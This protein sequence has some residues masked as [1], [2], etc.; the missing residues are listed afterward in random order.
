MTLPPDIPAAR[1]WSLTALRQPDALDAAD[2]AALPAGGEPVLPDTGGDRRTTTARRPSR[3]V[4]SDPADSP[5]G[6]WIQTDPRQ[7]L[8][9]DPAPLQPARSRSSTSPGAR[10]RSSRELSNRPHAVRDH[11][12]ERKEATHGSTANDTPVL[13]LLE[14]MTAASLAASS[15]DERTLMLVRIAALVA[16]DAPPVSY[17]MN[18]E[19]TAEV[20]ID[21]ERV[22][23]VLA[24]I[25][26]I[27]GTARVAA[28]TSNIVGALAL[29]IEVAELESQGDAIRRA[30]AMRREMTWARRFRL[31][32][33]LLES[34]WV[35]P[36]LG[37]V[38]G[39]VLGIVVSLADEHLGAPS[40]WQYSPSTASA[41]LTAIVGATAAL[42][43]FVV[44]VT[45]LV[46]QMAT[47]TFSARDPAPLVPRPPAEGDARG[48]RWHPHVLVLGAP[49][50]R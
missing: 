44:T 41:V 16:V 39:R 21:A 27:V 19:A 40:L 14:D 30:S 17:V 22:R 24:A 7:G 29:A 32:E 15:L 10:A 5:E 9:P 36:V 11:T 31:R 4:R 25:A 1:F 48:A 38:L 46:V 3:S 49:A 23:G 2:A 20:G 8:V 18:L 12:S 26:P 33:S 50:D 37:A 47:G 13:D 45:V 42:T 35:I 43:G 34:L 28:A 6:N